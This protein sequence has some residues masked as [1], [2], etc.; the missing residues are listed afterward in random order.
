MGGRGENIAYCRFCI[1]IKDNILA[2]TGD[3]ISQLGETLRLPSEA[4]DVELRNEGS[5]RGYLN[6]GVL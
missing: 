4:M 5:H 6:G 3:M 1:R 2:L